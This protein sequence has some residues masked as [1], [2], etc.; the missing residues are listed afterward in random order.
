MSLIRR[1]T[2]LMISRCPFSSTPCPCRATCVSRFAQ[3]WHVVVRGSRQGSNPPTPGPKAERLATEP[4]APANTTITENERSIAL[5]KLRIA[6]SH[7]YF[8]LDRHY[9]AT[10]VL[11]SSLSNERW[12]SPTPIIGNC[13]LVIS[14]R[15]PKYLTTIIR[16]REV[17]SRLR[18]PPPVQRKYC[19]KLS[20]G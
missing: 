6:W 11:L 7:A 15:T 8:C 12:I 17:P 5:S 16:S 9:N 3:G 18:L 14:V 19:V 4:P 20:A 2:L 13:K 10:Q 1:R